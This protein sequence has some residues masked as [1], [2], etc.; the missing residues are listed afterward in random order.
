M[1]LKDKCHTIPAIIRLII[2]ITIGTYIRII[3]PNITT[4][5]TTL[6]TVIHI[7]A[8]TVT[9]AAIQPM[10][11]YTIIRILSMTQTSMNITTQIGAIAVVKS[12]G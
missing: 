2:G 11:A 5:R 3:A 10:A 4:S 7:G 1:G 9:H 6:Y 8:N 12:S